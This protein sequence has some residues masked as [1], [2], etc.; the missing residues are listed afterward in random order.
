MPLDVAYLLWAPF[1][2]AFPRRFREH[3]ER[4][5]AGSEHRLVIAVSGHSDRYELEPLLAEFAGLAH[6]VEEFPGPSIDLGTYRQLVDRRADSD[7]FVFMNSYCRPLEADWLATFDANLLDDRVGV[8]GPGGSLESFVTSAPWPLRLWNRRRF[9][10]F[11]NPHIR[12]SCFALRRDA[13]ELIDWPQIDSK[14]QA[15]MFETGRRSITRQLQDH[16]LEPIVVGRG[17]GRFTV[18][19][20]AASRTFRSG[21]QENLLIADLRT[22]DYAEAGSAGRARLGRFA[23]GERWVP[24]A[25]REES[26]GRLAE[27]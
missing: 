3:Y 9:T 27:R 8:V 4:F 23:W 13:L 17:A 14:K 1:G 22:D 11:P 19:E 18:D 10:R 26:E 16:G 7:R 6:E 2:P 5:A 12:T 21:D 25:V 15:W 20:W 24:G